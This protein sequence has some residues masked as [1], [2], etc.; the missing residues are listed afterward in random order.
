MELDKG[1]QDIISEVS[2]RSKEI[3]FGNS[4]FQNK[5]F[6][7]A[8]EITPGRALRHC[9]LRLNNRIDALRECYYRHQ[10]DE[11]DTDELNYKLNIECD[12]YKKRRFA[13][14]LEQKLASKAK[15]DKLINDCKEEILTL[16]TAMKNLPSYNREQF[17]AEEEKHFRLKLGRD[18]SIMRNFPNTSGQMISLDNMG[19][20][21][22][23]I[24]SFDNGS[25]VKELELAMTDISKRLQDVNNNIS[26][27][28]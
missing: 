21:G 11:V 22:K 25:F 7:L 3:P 2:D 1:M 18:A 27:T 10:L 13:I 24:E 19:I 6:V 23:F 14:E 17:E 20:G 16:Y 26:I 12:A 5:V 4:E 28:E 15:S 9:L 8:N